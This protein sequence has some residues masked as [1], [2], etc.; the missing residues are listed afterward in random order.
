MLDGLWFIAQS[1]KIPH[2]INNHEFNLISPILAEK[3]ET[4]P[5]PAPGVQGTVGH[6][7]HPSKLDIAIAERFP[8]K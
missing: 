8:G 2:N 1:L 6:W 7:M 4:I 3:S 5:E